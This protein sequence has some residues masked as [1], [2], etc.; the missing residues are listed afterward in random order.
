MTSSLN[1][2]GIIK[3]LDFGATEGG[4]PYM[5]LEF[6]PG[7]TLRTIIDDGEPLTIESIVL[8]FAQVS[9]A[10]AGAHESGIFHRDLKPSNLLI[11]ILEVRL[12]DFGL[13]RLSLCLSSFLPLGPSRRFRYPWLI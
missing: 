1:H 8:F 9:R 7:S 4:V 5:A 6:F 10:L 2:P 12:I 13:A 3:I 11:F